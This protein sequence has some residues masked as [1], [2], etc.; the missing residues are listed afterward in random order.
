[1]AVP[2]AHFLGAAEVRQVHKN[3]KKHGYK[4]DKHKDSVSDCF[5]QQFLKMENISNAELF[6]RL[7][8]LLL[9]Q[10]ELFRRLEKLC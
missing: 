4:N 8:E 10:E 7:V 1:V 6:L 9:K 2:W 5:I 3:P